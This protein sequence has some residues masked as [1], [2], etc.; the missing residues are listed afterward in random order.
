ME[1]FLIISLCIIA[2]LVIIAIIL[3]PSQKSGLIGDATDVEK[4][5]KRGAELFLYRSTIILTILFFTLSLVYALV[6]SGKI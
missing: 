1:L 5:E 4:R 2:V 3:Q 6:V